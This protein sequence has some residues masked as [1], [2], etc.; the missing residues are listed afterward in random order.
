MRPLTSRAHAAPSNTKSV[1]GAGYI[2][3]RQVK[4][5]WLQQDRFHYTLCSAS[6]ELERG[7]SSLK[8]YEEYLTCVVV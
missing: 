6:L 4:A 1:E 5:R 2:Y 3:K 8:L 7:A